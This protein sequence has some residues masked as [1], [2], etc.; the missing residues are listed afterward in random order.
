MAFVAAVTCFIAAGLAYWLRRGQSV[1]IPWRPESG[2]VL[3]WLLL[4][5]R[6]Q[7]PSILAAT[8]IAGVFGQLLWG[9]AAQPLSACFLL[10]PLYGFIA[11]LGAAFMV[12]QA[13][14]QIRFERLLDVNLLII[15]PCFVVGALG[16]LIELTT[17]TSLGAAA[18]SLNRWFRGYVRESLGVIILTP[19]MV[20]GAH[21]FVHGRRL[22]PRLLLRVGLLSLVACVSGWF[23]FVFVPNEPMGPFPFL[24][25]PFPILVLAA[26]RFGPAGASL[27]SLL[28]AVTVLIQ[29]SRPRDGVA[30]GPGV[31]TAE[32]WW[33]QC[34]FLVSS[35]MGLLLAA[36][37]R[38]RQNTSC[39]LER[40]EQRSRENA[41]RLR[42]AEQ[43]ARNT[44]D[45][46]RRAITAANA[47]PYYRDYLTDRFVFMGEGIRDLTGYSAS[48]VTTELWENISREHVM[49]GATAGMSYEEAVRR[50]RAGEFRHWLSDALIVTQDGRERWIGDASVEILDDLGRPVGSIG[51]LIDITERMQ[52]EEAMRRAKE[53]LEGRIAER[54]AEFEMVVR[55]L[56]AFTYSISHDLR[57]PLRAIEGFSRILE[58]DHVQ[59][60]QGDGPSH[61]SRVRAAAIRMDMLINDLLVFARL[62]QQTMSRQQV[63]LNALVRQALEE[64]KLEQSN[65][66]I[67]IQHH[68]LPPVYGDQE[69]LRQVVRH[70]ISNALKYTRR[71]EVAEI[72][73]GWREEG[74]EIVYFVRDNGAG[75]DMAYAE[76][77]FGVFQK[78]HRTEEFEGSGVG[79]AI[80]HRI[81]RRHGGRI[82]ALSEVDRGAAFFF[83]LP[84]PAREPRPSFKEV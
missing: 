29:I 43:K 33:M 31:R 2:L 28:L 77:L 71:R 72:E 59:E 20:C 67:R 76:K 80:A 26:M 14:A 17:L 18:F 66:Q 55:E 50:T 40:S 39:A 61:L 44:E 41:E 24:Y 65:R 16:A 79:L 64:L 12:H 49:R 68:D 5:P 54:T 13:R 22:N 32:L 37:I 46:Y 34:Y 51:I 48:E 15:G 47:V 9:V 60:L 58:E 8:T 19:L 11:W 83:T 53:G 38:E 21:F 69:L 63:D 84:S 70:L 42:V 23:A 57:A 81:L 74:N 45:L 10:P 3:A 27:T 35:G 36:V 6:S 1:G 75:F 25:L 7:W 82:W 4:L 30:P 62:N 73:V 78:L 56:E 52:A